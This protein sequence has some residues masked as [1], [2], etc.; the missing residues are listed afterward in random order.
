MTVKT[1][2]VVN[3]INLKKRV[4][5][6]LHIYNQF[7][8]KQEF[9]FKVIEAFSHEVGA[10]GLWNTLLTVIKNA[11]K[12]GSDFILVC[13]DD[14]LF[15]ANYSYEIL[16]KCIIRAKR[17]DA[18]ILL[19]GVSWFKNGIQVSD[20]L[21]WVE[22]FSGLQFTVIFKKF[23]HK[24]IES[25]FTEDM[26]WDRLSEIHIDHIIPISSAETIDDLYKLNHYTNLQPLW[27][28]DNLAKYNKIINL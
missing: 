6:Y 8:T 15:T 22:K 23:Y 18:D 9:D 11:D 28:K 25:Q 16:E 13:E 20:S 4:D 3:I 10:I 2:I 26:N 7:E 21:F 1:P 17:L 24:I 14:H 12:F 5:R 27:A 19:G